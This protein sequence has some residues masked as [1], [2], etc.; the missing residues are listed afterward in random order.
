MKP[1]MTTRG[2]DYPGLWINF[3]AGEGAGKTTQ[4]QLLS[5]YLE[6]K[7]FFVVRGREPGGTPLS[8]QIRRMLLGFNDS[9]LSQK[10]ELLLFVTAGT[11][12]FE[13]VA[14]VVLQRGEI[15]VTD[16]WRYSTMAYQGYGLGLDMKMI[17]ALTEFSCDGA[18]PDITFLLD[19]N[20]EIGL[21]KIT[22]DEF[23]G[24]ERDRIESREANYHRRVNDGFREIA[25]QNPERIVVIPYLEGKPKLMYSQIVNYAEAF[26]KE[27]DLE[28]RL[29]RG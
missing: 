25:R 28:H 13:R 17:R 16:R 8:E 9:E 7:G 14:K 3:E 5:D 1:K 11:D 6:S 12:Y 24:S 2:H 15:L 23:A 18:Y 21:A 4:S 10:T 27:H 22:G 19:I 29:A 26:I 20:P